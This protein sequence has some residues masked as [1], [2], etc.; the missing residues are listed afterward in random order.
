METSKLDLTKTITKFVVGR[1]VGV[2]V[3]TIIKNNF[4]VESKTQKVQLFVG[5]Y[6]LGAMVGEGAAMYAEH[7]IDRMADWWTKVKDEMNDQNVTE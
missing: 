5:A 4:P 1:S 3:G 7:K 6:V 2:I